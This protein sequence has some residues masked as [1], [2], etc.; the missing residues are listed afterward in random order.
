MDGVARRVD[1]MA[2]LAP[3]PAAS[4]PPAATE[5]VAAAPLLAPAAASVGAP[6]AAAACTSDGVCN[7]CE[8]IKS[9]KE[10]KQNKINW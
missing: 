8:K 6:A 5:A 10:T 3:P 1:C 4:S 9:Q 2:W 7:I